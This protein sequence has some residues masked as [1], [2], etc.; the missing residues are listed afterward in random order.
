LEDLKTNG[1]KIKHK[2]RFTI[3]ISSFLGN[4]QRKDAINKRAGSQIMVLVIW[5]EKSKT[6]RLTEGSGF[7]YCAAP[8]DAMNV[9]Q[10]TV[11]RRLGNY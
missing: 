6:I 10:F 1:E 3:K 9:V 5:R 4:D 2:Q 7:A 11:A 8:N